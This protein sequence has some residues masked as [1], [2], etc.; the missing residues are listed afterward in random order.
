MTRSTWLGVFYFGTSSLF[1]PSETIVVD[2][3]G[4]L[5]PMHLF[6]CCVDIYLVYSTVDSFILLPLPRRLGA[7]IGRDATALLVH[8]Q[9]CY[10]VVTTR[11]R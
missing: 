1:L 3:A 5:R 9:G 2:M 11:N 4:M 8:S 10:D 7:L 6:K